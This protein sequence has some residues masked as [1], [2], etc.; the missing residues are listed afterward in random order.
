LIDPA[1]YTNSDDLS[2]RFLLEKQIAEA[3]L[4]AF[5]KSDLYPEIPTIPGHVTRSL[6]ARTGHGVR[7]WLDEVLSG[8]LPA[9]AK[10]LEIDYA[11]YARAEA[12]LGWLNWSGL[13]A[14]NEPVTPAELIGPW[15]EG[16]Q[17]RLRDRNAEVAHLKVLDQAGGAWLKAAAT[18]NDRDPVIEGDLTAS[19]EPVHAIRINIRAVIAPVELEQ[20]FKDELQRIA[21]RK[22]V[23]SFQ[24]F[25]PAAP[26]P[27]R[28]I[29]GE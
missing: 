20:L 1:R 25:S 19:P 15:V 24:C 8:E 16:L 28:R 4:V 3:D 12:A 27:E 11:A 5:S 7:A 10:S 23:S 6:S 21:G 18:S 29:V 2:I 13:V 22:I 26:E 17:R 9:G 14:L